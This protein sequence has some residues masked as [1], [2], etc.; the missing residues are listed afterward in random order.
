MNGSIS[1][2]MNKMLGIMGQDPRDLL[3]DEQI[4]QLLDATFDKFDKDG[5]GQLEKPEFRKA[6]DFLGLEGTVNEQNAAFDAVDAN[7]SG[8]VDRGEFKS[9]IKNSRSNELSLTVIMT[10]MDGHLEGLDGIFS[11]YKKKLEKAKAEAQARL[12]NSEEQFKMFQK[13]V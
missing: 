7:A 11:E 10:Q 13:T 5:S 6:W 3:T 12:A 8:I 2:I 9:A 4:N 1:K